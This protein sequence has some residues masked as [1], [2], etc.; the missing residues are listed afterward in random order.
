LVARRADKLE[1]LAAALGR[2]ADV[3][4]ADLSKPDERA[5][6]P[7]GWPSSVWSSTSWSTT[8]G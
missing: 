6:C 7:I 8:R 1:A 4:A 3:L 5:A 2:R